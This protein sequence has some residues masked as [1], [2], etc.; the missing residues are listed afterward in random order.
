MLSSCSSKHSLFF[1]KSYSSMVRTD[2]NVEGH[3]YPNEH[4]TNE[5]YWPNQPVRLAKFGEVKLSQEGQNQREDRR[6]EIAVVFQIRPKAN[7]HHC[8]KREPA[9]N[10]NRANTTKIVAYMSVCRKGNM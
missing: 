2:Q 8:A 10:K 5:K 6:E 3:K 4:E 7:L 1:H 9:G